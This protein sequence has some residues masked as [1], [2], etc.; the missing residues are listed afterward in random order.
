LPIEFNCIPLILNFADKLFVAVKL[1]E[2]N[3]S[4]L[5][6]IIFVMRSLTF[7]RYRFSINGLLLGAAVGAGFAAFESAGYALRVGLNLNTTAM[8]TN[9]VLRGVFSPFGHIVWSAIAVCAFW[10]TRQFHR[11][12]IDTLFDLR[13]LIIFSKNK[14]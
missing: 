6:T 14:S 10:R 9:I 2:A 5:F 3:A 13:F 7:N 8:V 11:N 4:K 1:I 12:N